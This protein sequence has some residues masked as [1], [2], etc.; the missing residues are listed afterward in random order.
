MASS[1]P[2]FN[3]GAPHVVKNQNNESDGASDKKPSEVENSEENGKKITLRFLFIGYQNIASAAI[4]ADWQLIHSRFSSISVAQ[5]FKFGLNRAQ[6][7]IVK[8]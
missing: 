7:R 8:I 4:R 5:N 1:A 2:F 3:Y 6:T